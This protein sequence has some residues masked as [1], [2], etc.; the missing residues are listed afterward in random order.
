[1]PVETLSTST[2]S[3]GSSPELLADQENLD[4][5]EQPGRRG[6]VIQRLHRVCRG[7][8]RR[9]A[10]ST[11]PCNEAPGSA[12]SMMSE[13]PPAMIASSPVRAR[14]T[15]PETGA[16]INTPPALRT[17]SAIR[18]VS[19][20]TPELISMTMV[21]G[22]KAA[23][24]PVSPCITRATIVLVGN[25]VIRISAPWATSAGVSAEVAP[26]SDAKARIRSADTS[27][28]INLYPAAASRAAIGPAHRAKADEADAGHRSHSAGEVFGRAP[29]SFSA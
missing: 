25:M 24:A 29:I 27:F 26:I 15:P 14:D 11:S 3:A 5:R 18:R 7:R 17:V 28:T 19:A 20:G 1:M 6:K 22:R 8:H 21:R 2:M 4:G 12:R 16:S 23:Q 9:C 13:G 10:G